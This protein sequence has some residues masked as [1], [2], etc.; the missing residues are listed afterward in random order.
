MSSGWLWWRRSRLYNRGMK[1]VIRLTG[2]PMSL[3]EAARQIGIPRRRQLAILKILG[4]KESEL[5]E[6]KVLVPIKGY[7]KSATR[8]RAS[9]KKSK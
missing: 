2:P 8:K 3:Q 9:G 1:K 7:G 5:T 6:N 4:L